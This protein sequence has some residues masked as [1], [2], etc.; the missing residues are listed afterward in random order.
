VKICVIGAG[1]VGL[2]TAACFAD[3]GN[4]VVCI[5]NNKAK[6]A[7]LK[8]GVMPIFEPGL[9]EMI[10]RNAKNTR[11]SFGADI[12]SAAKRSTVIFIAVGTPPKPSGEPDLSAIE[13]VTRQIAYVLDSSYKIIVEKSTVPVETGEWVKYTLNINSK[14]KVNFD[15]ASNPEFLREGSAISD[16]MHPDR[17]V[18][19]VESKKAKDVL[20]ELFKPFKAPII[21]TDIKS[22]EIIKHASNSFLATKISF[23]NAIARVCDSS[24]ADVI[25]VA[26]GM[27]LDKRIGKA[28]L[29]AG[30]GWGGFCFPKDMLAFIHISE[31]LGYDFKLLK[32]A[33]SINEEQKRFVVEKIRQVLGKLKGNTIAVLGLAFKPNTDD[34]RL[35]VAVDIIKLLKKEGARIRAY[36]PKAAKKAAEEL[37]GVVFC[38]DAYDAAKG[39]DALV[40]LTEWPEFTDLDLGRLK[41]LLRLPIIVDARNIYD[42]D[43]IKRAGFKYI[44]VGRR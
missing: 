38:K 30:A 41:R 16:F 18:L 10:L 15:V 36:D 34:I 42:P 33:F 13:N 43:L 22:S 27:G 31:K 8:K 21:I 40:V 17:I 44:G 39:S 24:G 2:V 4:D 3:L 29:N 14:K 28:F 35:A 26:E 1:Y 12:K 32:E 7:G 20:L 37:D 23:I 19:G 5:D 9:E 11:L 6:I 25:K